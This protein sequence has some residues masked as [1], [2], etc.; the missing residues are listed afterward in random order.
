MSPEILAMARIDRILETLP[1][2]ARQRVL[3]WLIDKIMDGRQTSSTPRVSAAACRHPGY[4]PQ[5]ESPT[6]F[7]NKPADQLLKG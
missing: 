6:L 3:T 1:Q 4:D 7:E 2:L 5:K